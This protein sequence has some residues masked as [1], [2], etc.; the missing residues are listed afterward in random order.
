MRAGSYCLPTN[1]A[2]APGRPEPSCSRGA[3]LRLQEAWLAEARGDAAEERR[4]LEEFVHR[5]L[6][7]SPNRLTGLVHLAWV[8]FRQGD[9]QA[10]VATCAESLKFQRRLGPSRF[11][12]AVLNV[13][14]L[15]GEHSGLLTL[16][17]RLSATIAAIKGQP[18][19]ISAGMVH[20]QE[21]QAAAVERVRVAL[22]EAAFAAAWA[23]GE[24]LS[25]DAAI[26]F[27]L[28]AV[29]ELQQ[30]FAKNTAAER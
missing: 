21:E 10:A 27:G 23:A 7:E 22:G 18:N 1:A 29:A 4:L 11:L 12:P 5:V 15:A 19:L 2:H 14:A 9:I 20:L 30:V 28:E 16:S 6:V 26:E 13:L 25:A 17:A 24:R 3:S 8:A